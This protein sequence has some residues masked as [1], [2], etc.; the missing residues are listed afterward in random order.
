MV[1]NCYSRP[2]TQTLFRCHLERL[3]SFP[4]IRKGY[5]FVQGQE[6]RSVLDEDDGRQ[7]FVDTGTVE[8][9]VSSDVDLVELDGCE[10]VA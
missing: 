3:E 1:F 2:S 10:L 7:F 5:I 9:G 6:V 8:H 4:N